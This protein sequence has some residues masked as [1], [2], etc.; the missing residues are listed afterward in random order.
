MGT[1]DRL[2]L[3]FNKMILNAGLP[4]SIR[5]YYN[6]VGSGT[7][8]VYDEPSVGGLTLS[9]TI[10]LSGIYFGISPTN[11]EDNVLLEQ[12]KINLQDKRLYIPGSIILSPHTGSVFQNKIGIGSPG[13][14]FYSILSEG[15]DAED[16]AGVNIYKKVFI[17]RLTNGSLIG[18]A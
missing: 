1:A 9:G 13:N 12:G 3:G 5:Y 10:W 16:I 8:S 7:G 2:L 4:V 11:S 18:E 17:R 15:A 6:N 14:D